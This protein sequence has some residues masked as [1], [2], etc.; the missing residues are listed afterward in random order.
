LTNAPSEGLPPGC[1]CVLMAPGT[2]YEARAQN[3]DC[4]VH[5]PA[6]SGRHRARVRRGAVARRHNGY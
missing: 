1:R 2:T 3:P 5:D 4:P 6:G